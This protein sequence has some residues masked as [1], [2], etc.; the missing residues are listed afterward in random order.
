[1]L[2]Y[3]LPTFLLCFGNLLHETWLGLLGHS[4]IMPGMNIPP[5]VLCVDGPR[6]HSG[7]DFWLYDGAMVMGCNRGVSHRLFELTE[8][9]PPSTDIAGRPCEMCICVEES[10]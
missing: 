2:E 6:Q 9:A 1:M 8:Y 7:N 4:L 3:R 10:D 5:Q